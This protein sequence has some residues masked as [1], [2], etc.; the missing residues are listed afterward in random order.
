MANEIAKL[1]VTL[2]MDDKELQTG[3][4]S[5][6]KDLTQVGK[7]MTGIG[8]TVTASLGLATK[9][10]LDEQIGINQLSQSLKN[11]GADYN[12][13]SEEIEKNLAAT[14]KKT[15]FGDGEQRAALAELVSITGTYEGALEQLSIAV[16]LA[17]AKDM[18]LNSAAT[19]IG[20][21]VTG[22]TALLKRYGIVVGEG[23]TATEAL[24]TIQE[25]FNGAAEAAADPLTQIKNSFGDLVEDI[26]SALIPMFK[27]I[28]DAIIPI[29]DKV[30]AWMADNPK[31][32][33]TITIVA[34]VVGVLSTAIGSFLLL[35]PTLAAGLGVIT[36]L[37]SLQTIA[38]HAHTIALVAHA[39]ATKVVTAAQWLFN[40]AMMA[41]P[42]G[43]IIAAV[44]ALI[45][46][47]VLLVKNWDKVREVAIKVWETIKEKTVEVW[48]NIVNFFKG[49]WEK[50]SSLFKDNW[51]KILAILFPAVGVPVLIARNWDKIKDYFLGLWD[52]IKNVFK[53]AIN[54]IIGL[55]EGFVN[56]W[57]KGINMIIGALNALKVN[58][59]DWVPGLGGKTFGVNISPVS[60]V[61]LPRLAMGGIA[62]KPTVAVVG[63]NPAG[64]AIIPLDK[65]GNT[66]GAVNIYVSGSVISERELF[67]LVQRYANNFKRANGSTGLA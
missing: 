2:G 23:A 61:Q 25:R 8:A 41:N 49:V 9:A 28:V 10:A 36:K 37:L 33:Q 22:D 34:A 17:A 7:Y 29:I 13:L 18:D 55:A 63:D 31:L 58:I 51:D 26:G 60:E 14:Q 67:S 50:V 46:I 20:R 4:K 3:L 27:N 39:V 30:R 12:S 43:L 16:D 19:L 53:G 57:I 45:A 52:N 24:T 35:L 1:F 54:W 48:N 42:I 44:I 15:S 66:G 65:L 6:Q 38:A 56:N 5:M 62:M 11:V 40:A 32:T 59:P 21:T 64:E 47:I